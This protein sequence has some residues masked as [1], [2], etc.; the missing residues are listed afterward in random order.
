MNLL[1]RLIAILTLVILPG[2]GLLKLRVFPNPYDQNNE[3]ISLVHSLSLSL[4]LCFSLFIY[5]Y[6]Y[7]YIKR[8]IK[9]SLFLPER[10]RER[11]T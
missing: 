10:E 7:I 9:N 3:A 1:S 2:P 11:H 6:I 5:I 4:S 8:E